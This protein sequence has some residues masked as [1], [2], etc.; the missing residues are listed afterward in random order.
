MEFKCS[1][2]C[3]KTVEINDAPYSTAKCPYCGAKYEWLRYGV[4]WGGWGNGPYRDYGSRPIQFVAEG[5]VTLSRA[6]HWAENDC[7]S[8]AVVVESASLDRWGCPKTS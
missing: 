7:Q 1:H 4:S 8:M 3:P 2:N 5:V 6:H